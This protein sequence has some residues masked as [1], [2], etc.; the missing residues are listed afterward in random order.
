MHEKLDA[1][2]QEME[3]NGIWWN[4]IT[5]YATRS[6]IRGME[7]FLGKIERDPLHTFDW[8]VCVAVA[9]GYRKAGLI[10]KC[11]VM[12]KRVEGLAIGQSKKRAY[13]FLLTFYGHAKKKEEVYRL[14]EMCKSRWSVH[15]KGYLYLVSSLV[16]AD[17]LEGAENIIEE[18][19]FERAEALLNKG[20]SAWP[21][22]SYKHMG[23]SSW[24]SLGSSPPCLGSAVTLRKKQLLDALEDSTTLSDFSEQTDEDDAE[25]EKIISPFEDDKDI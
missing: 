18:G 8:I 14:W 23:H 17:D 4:K 24:W 2:M 22:T 20:N 19:D 15:N 9:N 13:Q 5:A 12:L 10:D 1:I 11:V 3:E 21:G 6:D 7:I 25:M 16:K